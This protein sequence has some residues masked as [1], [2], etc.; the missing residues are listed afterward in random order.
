MQQEDS[1]FTEKSRIVAQDKW[2]DSY[3]L[4][5]MEAGAR[6]EGWERRE[7]RSGG[8]GTCVDSQDLALGG[9]VPRVQRA[10]GGAHN[11]DSPRRVP[12]HR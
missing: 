4:H 11:R 3:Q 7:V 9:D 2:K 12:G 10:L 1:E 8:G 5:K 6:W